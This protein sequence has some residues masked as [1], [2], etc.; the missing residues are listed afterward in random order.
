MSVAANDRNDRLSEAH[1]AATLCLTLLTCVTVIGLCRVFAGWDYLKPMLVVA[2]GVHSVAF[3]LRLFRAP[4][5]VSIPA[6]LL[7]IL[8]IIG[9]VYY[10]DTLS[11]F[12]PTGSTIDNIRIDLRLVVK[13]FASAVAPVPGEGSFATS[14][15]G[16]IATAVI[17][18]DTF[19]FR[20]FGRVEAVVPTGVIFVFTS[21]LGVNNHRVA[22][23]VLWI[24]AALLT[25]AMLRF[26][27]ADQETSWM[28]SRSFTLAAALPAIILTVGVSAI[29]AGAVGPRLPGAGE[30][31]LIDTRHRQGGITEVLS[32]LVDIR[33][34]MKNHGNSELFTV[35]S[36]NG[37]HYWREIGLPNFDGN[38]WSPPHEDLFPMGDRSGDVLQPGSSVSQ[39]YTIE[40][41]GGSLVPAAYHPA[42]V[43]DGRVYWAGSTQS[44]VLADD[45]VLQRGDTLQVTSVVATPTPELLRNSSTAQTD[46][47]YYSLPAGLPRTALDAARL[48]TV[49][50]ATAY[51]KVMAIQAWFQNNFRYDLTVQLG[52]SN[53]AIAA[54]LRDKRGFCQQFA[55]TF[56]VMARSLN[57]PARVA[58]GYTQGDLLSDGLYHVFGRHAHAWPEVWFDNVGWVA[59][60]P[61]PSRGNPDAVLYTGLQ[62]NQD[63][64]GGTN[65]QG[66]T[67]QTTPPS[68]TIRGGKGPGDPDV[69]TTLPHKGGAGGATTTTLHKVA[70]GG[71][72]SFSAVPI[73]MFALIVLLALWVLLA[74]RF[75]RMVNR[76]HSRAARD[77]VASTWVRACNLLS[78]AGAPPIGGATPLEYASVARDATGVDEGILRELAVQVTRAVY[79]P[80]GVDEVVATQCERLEDEVDAMCKPRIPFA[81]RVRALLDPRMMRRRIAG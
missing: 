58:V 24:G 52:N 77:R 37:A 72:R 48:V 16:L 62:P 32:P 35:Q 20:A 27:H 79:S 8:G 50:Q 39:L 14:T 29:A 34:R 30:K 70:G 45:R 5:W 64:T 66:Q 63:N 36:S 76:S 31:A 56:A 61:T 81:L 65:N 13:E 2:I 28:G 67:G 3:A 40:S 38:S 59:F 69:S 42:S 49:G 80:K 41:L 18:A 15:A 53:D 33:A 4:L 22:T 23:A 71:S 75:L 74:P 7:S 25:I 11:F 44:L 47:V 60:E 26:D 1:P 19:A 17:L 78:L 55:G 12:L 51:D 73:V 43:S 46:P 68:T 9:I 6:L 21:A 57:I 54:F 10:S